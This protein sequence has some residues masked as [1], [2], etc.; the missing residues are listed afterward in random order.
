MTTSKI[1]RRS[2]LQ[3][4]GALAAMT[5]LSACSADNDDSAA[6]NSNSDKIRITFYLWDRSMMKA[7]TPWLEQKFPEYEFNFLLGFNSME[8]YHD[9]LGRA[10]QLPD[11]ITCRRFSL[12]DA[13]SL[14]DHLAD[15]STTEVAGTFYASYLNTN[16]EPGGAI[17]W[18]PM[19]AE[20]DG[21]VAN[22]DLF[23]QH[24]IPLPTNYAEFVDAIDAFEA[25]GIKGYGADWAYDYTC[26]ETMQGCAIPELM[27]LEGTA[28]RMNYESEAQDSRTGLDDVVWPTVFEKYEQ[29]LKDVRVQPGDEK[30]EL[31]PIAKPF[32]E[33]KTAMLRTTASAADN[34]SS[35]YGFNT[36]VLPYFGETDKDGW[37]LTYPMC[38]TAVSNTAAQDETKLAAILRVLQAMYSAEGQRVLAAGGSVLS[39]NKEVDTTSSKALEHDNDIIAAN[40]LYVRLASTE[41][42]SISQEVGHKMIIGEY[43]AKAAYEAFNDQLVSPK[44]NPET[45]VLFT[46]NIAYPIDMTEHGSAA[47][48]SVLTALRATYNAD[49]A[50]GYSPIVS[51]SIYCG[52]YT[53]QQILWVMAGNYGVTQGEYTGAE[54]LQMMEWLVN[55]KENGAN[56]IRHRSF[57]PVTSGMEYKVTEYERCKF[58]LEE[59]TVN[60]E[61]LNEAATYTVFVAG[62]DVWMEDENFCNCPMPESLKTKRMDYAIEG[63][64]SRSCLKE[65]LANSK[66]FPAPSNYLTII[67]GA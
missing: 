29:F 32:F 33:Q 54:L 16:K 8:Y 62:T 37:L 13:A 45:E 10:E 23:E 55:V 24:G 56:P 41:I 1:S 20:V 18:L 50:V 38:Q 59:V 60:G 9:L 11:I 53:T 67:Q 65:S 46:Q 30:Y 66:Q 48:S 58:R 26:L 43:D 47:A 49:I 14:A 28:W 2:F 21:T 31:N 4:S 6:S 27:S 40:H 51:T 61:P 5:T 3:A 35:T 52:D 42:F 15:L 57:M 12:N 25:A 34:I 36:V 17:R 39:Y 19:C 63:A 7:L 64:D 44:K 22:V